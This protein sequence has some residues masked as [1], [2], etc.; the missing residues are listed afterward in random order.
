MARSGGKMALDASMRIW[1]TM[2]PPVLR[3][4][5]AEIANYALV[6]LNVRKI[7]F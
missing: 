5:V 7:A 6:R 3:H 4:F 1:L 2:F